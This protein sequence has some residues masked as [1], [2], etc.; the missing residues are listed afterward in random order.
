MTLEEALAAWSREGD[1]RGVKAAEAERADVLARFPR[2]SWPDMPVE[3]YALGI[4]VDRLR[5]EGRRPVDGLYVTS[6][7][8]GMKSATYV[9]PTYVRISADAAR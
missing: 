3:R 2:E 7:S 4:G 8:A 1:A 9:T 5:G 6:A